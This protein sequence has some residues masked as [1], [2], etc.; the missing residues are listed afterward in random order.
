LA[1]A[2]WL[3][4]ILAPAA[5]QN[6]ANR[7]GAA[8][9]AGAVEKPA[10]E[11]PQGNAGAPAP[12]VEQRTRLNLLGQTDTQS[13]E[14][15]RNENVQFNLVDNNLLRELNTRL[16]TTAT[17]VTEFRPDR[18]Y[19]SAEYGNSPSSTLHVAPGARAGIH[20]RLFESHLNSVFSA[21]SFF[22]VGGVQPARENNYGVDFLA[23]VWKRAVLSV[24][25]SQQKARGMV[26][27]N[28]L[29]PLASERTPLA[30]DPALA[31]YVQRI[32]SSYPAEEP[33]RTDIN[34]RML[35]TN[36]PQEINSDTASARIDQT[37][38]PRDR[39]VLRYQLVH[40]RV[41]A[42]QFVKGQNPDTTTRS[43]QPRITWM[44]QALQ[45]RSTSRSASTAS[46][47]SSSPKTTTWE[48]C[49]RPTDSP[50]SAPTRTCPSTAPKTCSA[51]R[52][53]SA[54]FVAGTS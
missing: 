26:N 1:A 45:R 20:G 37:L 3:L 16:G 23:P 41:L 14:S 5:G 43:H 25:A 39:L 13:G 47:R 19:Y 6:P 51:R 2:C 22:Q 42:F 7:P 11:A 31:A 4:A 18:G 50:R 35:N 12:A 24:S 53:R 29:V 36:S 34:K 44:R 32:L 49:S 33:N 48:G 54:T 28:I 52:R 9:P 40:Q 30:T 38:N 46:P 27:G 17:I 21:R 8:Q 15:R 10:A